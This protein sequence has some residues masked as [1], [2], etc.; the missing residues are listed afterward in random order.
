MDTESIINY[1]LG[2]GGIVIGLLSSIYFYL[3][4]KEVKEPHIYY[5][6]Y[7]N[8]DKIEDGE[9]NSDVKIFYKS[10][11]V[12]RVFTTY[13]WFFNRGKKPITA[14]DVPSDAE[15]VLHLNSEENDLRILDYKIIKETRKPINANVSKINERS[16]ST[17]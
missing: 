12:D 11:E 10:E 3:R 8:I 6:T 2:I 15:L 5:Q 16:L 1:S 13:I 17:V 4:S 9:Q 14:S 7:K